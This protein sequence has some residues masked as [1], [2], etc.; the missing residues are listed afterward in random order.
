MDN[1]DTANAPL[2]DDEYRKFET[3][4]DKMDAETFMEWLTSDGI[5]FAD[6]D[7]AVEERH[8]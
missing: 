8:G 2:T 1:L 6:L 4:I 3:A 7:L 5:G